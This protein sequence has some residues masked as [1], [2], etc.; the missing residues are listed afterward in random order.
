MPN[1]SLCRRPGIDDD[2]PGARWLRDRRAVV[3]A[4]VRNLLGQA[5]IR[6]LAV[7]R[8]LGDAIEPRRDEVCAHGAASRT[9]AGPGRRDSQQPS[10]PAQKQSE[11]A[12]H[13]ADDAIRKVI[14]LL[15]AAQS[16][17]VFQFP[18]EFFSLFAES[19]PREQEDQSLAD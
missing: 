3:R 8:P 11:T 2:Q 16:V 1:F 4:R 19:K 12:F 18:S 14:Q 15:E 6:E 9:G 17:E 10:Q 7:F 13:K 5:G